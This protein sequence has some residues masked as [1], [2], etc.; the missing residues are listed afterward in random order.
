VYGPTRHSELRLLT[1]AGDFKT[2]QYEDN[3][4]VYAELTD[5]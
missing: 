2:A 4:V 1:C 5:G 3:L